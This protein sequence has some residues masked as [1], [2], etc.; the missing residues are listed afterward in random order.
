MSTLDALRVLDLSDGVAGAFCSK[1][2][3]GYGADVIAVESP[4]GSPLRRLGP[5]VDPT[6]PLETGAPWLCLAVGKRSVTL[7]ITTRTG[8]AVFRK[9]TEEANVIIETYEPGRMAALGLGYAALQRIKNRIVLT[10]ITPYGQTGSRAH[11]KATALTSLAS[12]GRLYGDGDTLIATHEAE[13]R[14]GLEAFAATAVA[15]HNADSFEVPQH[16]DISVQECLLAALTPDR[17]PALAA[18]AAHD[19]PERN[20]ERIDHPIAGERAYPG[21]PFRMSAVDWQQARAPLLGEHSRGVLCDETGLAGAEFI[22]LR[23]AG[24]A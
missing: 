12:G 6:R 16:V 14:A 22:R 5:Y 17:A 24:V 4:A 20:L 1:L 23:A 3:A 7:D 2:F 10:S 13:Y 11:W 21:A 15:A 8:A 19:L 18:V 9:M